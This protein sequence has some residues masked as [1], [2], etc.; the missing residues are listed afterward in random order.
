MNNLNKIP[1]HWEWVTLDDIGIVVSGGTPSTKEPEFW[2]GNIPWITP[3]DLSGHEDMFIS[4][5]NRNISQAGLDYSS[6]YLLPENSVVFSSRAPIGYV[7]ITKNKLATNQGFKNLILPCK[8]VNP[9]YVFYYLKT[10]KEL[11]ENMAS[12]TTFLE[13]STNKFKQ[14]PFPLAPIEEQN[15]IVEKIEELFSELDKSVENL[16]KTKKKS[17]LSILS[18]YKQVFN[19]DNKWKSITIRD[20]CHISYGKSLP[21]K[22]RVTGSFPVYGANGIV[23]WHNMALTTKPSIII[24][25]KG[26]VGELK[27][28]KEICFPIDTTYYIEENGSFNLKF[29]FYQLKIKNLPQLSKSTTIPGL[30]REHIYD[31]NIMIP[32]SIEE[33]NGIVNYIEEKKEDLTLL[34]NSIVNNI[35][36]IKVVYQKILKDAFEGKLVS[37]IDSYKTIQTLIDE[38]TDEKNKFIDTKEENLKFKTTSKR[39]ERKLIEILLSNFKDQNFSFED[40]VDINA[41]ALEKLEKEFKSLLNEGKISKKYDVQSKSIKFK[42]S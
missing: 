19:S 42:L 9:K 11:A 5:G 7:A 41:M 24:G 36:K 32:S 27:F 12:G 10:I 40:I 26:S 17:D 38:I 8:L 23:G 28:S 2:N 30:N 6:A 29:L 35:E 37:K 4:E 20:L 25:R 15:R 3:A 16:E 39:S 18:L 22:D 34:Q 33:Q 14:I 31:L 1:S 21:Q 13:L